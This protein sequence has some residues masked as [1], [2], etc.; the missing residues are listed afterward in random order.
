M[1][2]TLAAFFLA[3]CAA[4]KEW[5]AARVAAAWRD[6]RGWRLD[7]SPAQLVLAVRLALR[8]LRGGLAGFWVFLACIALGVASISGVAGVSRSLLAGMGKEGR[9]LLGGDVQFRLAQ[10]EPDAGELAALKNL[11]D[12]TYYVTTRTMAVNA[13]EDD[14][15]L[16]ELKA[17]DDAYPL[18]GR[19]DTEPPLAHDAL[20]GARGGVYGMA[21]D[22]ALV[23]RFDLKPGDKVKLGNTWFEY[24]A[25]IVHEPDAIA[26]R[27]GFGPRVLISR[28][29]LAST[30][31]IAFGSIAGRTV[32]VSLREPVTD[33]GRLER[34]SEEFIDAFPEAAWRA[35]TRLK[36]NPGFENGVERFTQFLTLV[37][38]TALLVGGVGVANAVA[39]FVERKRTAVAVMKSL[40]G[41]GR[42]IVALYLSEVLLIAAIGIV[43]GLTVGAALPFVLSFAAAAVLPVPVT[44][45]IAADE[46]LLAAF[47]GV[48]VT[49]VFSVVPLGRAHDMSVT[50]LFRDLVEETAVPVRPEYR[51]LAALSLL[52]LAG[53]SLGVSYDRAA[54]ALFIF[55]ISVCFLV[56]RGVAAAVMALARRAPRVELAWW[57]LA[58]GNLHRP[59]ALTPSLVLSLGLCTTLMVALAVVDNN[60]RNQ[61]TV[62]IA[63]R[64]PSFFFLDVTDAGYPAFETLIKSV[65]PDGTLERAP[66][67]RGRIIRVNNTPAGRL[68]VDPQTAG[69]LNGE[70]GVT[71]MAE[72]PRE[73]RVVEGH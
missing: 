11:G 1:R 54:G 4:L 10:R 26:L 51:A 9:T 2:E 30:S 69:I 7:L 62:S 73:A 53:I 67:M 70:R 49:L 3:V 34:L 65:A 63:K 32:N 61:L 13:A 37:G 58:V 15:T 8:E 56:L 33:D 25:S 24:R 35:R 21:A 36:A 59:G 44:P 6:V 23:L 39:A 17:V 42:F 19:L 41:S 5:A 45:F 72:P 47:Y 16:V 64:A 18:A 50:R 66:N 20:L 28:D 22:P 48:L 14:V 68:R 57:R 40:G 46:L 38:L 55:A 12:I 29:G 71:F 60:L 43:I 52:M 31:L 27:I